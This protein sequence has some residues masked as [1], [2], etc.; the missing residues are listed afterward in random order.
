MDRSPSARLFSQWDRLPLAAVL[1]FVLAHMAAVGEAPS[2]AY[3]A[4][5]APAKYMSPEN[6]WRE[7]LVIGGLVWGLLWIMGA[8]LFFFARGESGGVL[9]M[10]EPIRG[11]LPTGIVVLF[12]CLLVS[13]SKGGAWVYAGLG[14]L[15]ACALTG[16]V[17]SLKR[18]PH[19]TPLDGAGNEIGGRSACG[20]AS[21]ARAFGLFYFCKE[22]PRILAPKRGGGITLNLAHRGGRGILVF[23]MALPLALAILASFGGLF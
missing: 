3:F 5:A 6:L 13:L 2:L 22:D 7:V 21:A 11:T 10:L 17:I 12:L 18:L 8:S 23:G 16:L 9:S 15:M 19:L 14:L 4:G 1:A 20:A